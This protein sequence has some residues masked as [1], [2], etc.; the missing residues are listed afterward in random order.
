MLSYAVLL[1]V[2]VGE[3]VV[4]LLWFGF[5]QGIQTHV[6]MLMEQVPAKPSPQ[7]WSE[8]FAL[9]KTQTG[10]SRVLQKFT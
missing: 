2:G 6:L 1:R 3:G 4:L 5:M 7:P 10:K 9:E 8:H